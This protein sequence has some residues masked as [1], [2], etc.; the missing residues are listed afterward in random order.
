MVLRTRF[1]PSLTGFLHR[2]HALHMA[3]VWGT[4][5]RLGLR[6]VLR[7]EDHDR[8]RDRPAYAPAVVADLAW[9]GYVPHEGY[10]ALTP[11]PYRQ[12]HTP[13]R[14]AAALALLQ[15]HHEVYAC[16][17]SRAQLMGRW[18]AV[19]RT[20]RPSEE[21]PYDGHCRHR[22]LEAMRHRALRL[23]VPEDLRVPWTDLLLGPHTHQPAQQCGHL[24]LRDALGQYTYQLCVVADDLAH[25]ITHVVRGQDVLP[26]TGRQIWLR[27]L[28]A[29]TAPPLQW[30]HH[31]LLTDGQGQ[32]LSKRTHAE[33]LTALRE[34]GVAAE[35]VR[36]VVI[37]SLTTLKP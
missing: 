21:V 35:E 37:Q 24:L 29:P 26:S 34:K 9:L 8:T 12:S 23:V 22:R 32:K 5:D 1:A 19:G 15:Q 31:P 33:S 10:Q 20:F 11:D 36:C 30:L 13:E 3:W 16:S 25:G 18:Q 4:A 28:L 17:C 14:Y 6:V 2:G 27:S 7:M